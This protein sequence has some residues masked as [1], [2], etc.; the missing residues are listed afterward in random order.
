MTLNRD[1]RCRH[2]NGIINDECIAGVNYSK[3]DLSVN[4]CWGDDDKCKKYTPLT[5]EE[6]DEKHKSLTKQKELFLKG[7]SGCCEAPLDMS[8]VYKSGRY[9]GHGPRLCSK[10]GKLVALA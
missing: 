10:C 4:S 7:L 1:K 5:K 6:I 3:I 8:R 9:K 2:F